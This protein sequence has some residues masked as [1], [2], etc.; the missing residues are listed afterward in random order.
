MKLV[1]PIAKHLTSLAGA[2]LC[3]L[4]PAL[5]ARA[6]SVPFET[7]R[8]E[9]QAKESRVMNH[10]GRSSLYLK[11]GAAFGGWGVTAQFENMEGIKVDE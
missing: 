5:E 11:G 10:L 7:E 1:S 8:W 6:Q 9:I 3:A 2:F 4:I